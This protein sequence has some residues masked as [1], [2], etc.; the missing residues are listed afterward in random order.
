MS[1]RFVGCS[2]HGALGLVTAGT[3]ESTAGSDICLST[4]MSTRRLMTGRVGVHHFSVN[5]AEYGA[6]ATAVRLYIG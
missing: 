4:Y 6:C 5:F 1:D 3:W 2:T